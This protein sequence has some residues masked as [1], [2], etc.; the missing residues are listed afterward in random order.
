LGIAGCIAFDHCF[1]ARRRGSFWSDAITFISREA[2]N[3]GYNIKLACLIKENI[4][5]KRE[6]EKLRNEARALR[7]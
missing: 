7:R 3:L 6:N 1:L 4:E 5:L 2:E